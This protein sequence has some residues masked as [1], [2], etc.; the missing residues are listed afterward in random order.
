MLKSLIF[1]TFLLLLA[2]GGWAAPARKKS[3]V[4]TQK[5]AVATTTSS[6]TSA[7]KIPTSKEPSQV[8][9]QK[10]SSVVIAPV[11]KPLPPKPFKATYAGLAAPSTTLS[12][13]RAD[14]T[15]DPH[16]TNVL[17]MGTV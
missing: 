5:A 12:A 14:M 15:V 11:Q 1:L 8:S 6:R 9:P 3:P 10:I 17:Q 2:Q 4:N 7:K 13:V 16:Y